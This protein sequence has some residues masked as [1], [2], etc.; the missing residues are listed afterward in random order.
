M[1]NLKRVTYDPRTVGE[2]SLFSEEE[3]TRRRS[4]SLK[5]EKGHSVFTVEVE[6][7][8]HRRIVVSSDEGLFSLTQETK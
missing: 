5:F 8:N 3:E 6:W 2:G 7:K 4:M 1:S